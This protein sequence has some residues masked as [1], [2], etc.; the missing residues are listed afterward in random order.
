MEK[1]KSILTKASEKIYTFIKPHL[2][3]ETVRCNL[4]KVNVCSD[5]GLDA[6]CREYYT[7][8][9]RNVMLVLLVFLM[10]T[11]LLMTR[12]A[13]V[14]DRSMVLTRDSYGGDETTYELTAEKNGQSAEFE[15]ELQ[16]VVYGEDEIEAVFEQS[17]VYIE[18]NFLGEN[19]SCD[20]VSR[21][22]NLMDEIPDTGISVVWIS[23]D[24]GS[25]KSTGE[26]TDEII[27]DPR[28]ITL[29]ACLSYGDYQSE[30]EYTVRLVGKEYTSL[31]LDINAIKSYI[32]EKTAA[33]D[34]VQV[35]VPDTIYG[36]HISRSENENTYIIF[37]IMGI[38]MA[39]LV[40]FKSRADLKTAGDRRNAELML[41]Y[42]AFV[43]RLSLY[44]GAGLNIRGALTAVCGQ[45]D[46]D[47]LTSDIL[48][49]E[50][51]YSLNQ[52]NSGCLETDVYYDLGHRLGLTVYMKITSLLCQNLKKGTN[53][54][55]EQMATEELS[56]LTIR[57]ENARKRGEEAG[58]KLLFPMIMLLVT[59]MIIVMLPALMSF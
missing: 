27:N 16:P 14:T 5:A 26:I 54:L 52:L 9:I 18:E 39:A 8:L 50:I 56:A 41:R 4:R 59:V 43:E 7:G 1:K 13:F 49:E 46:E 36:Y 30:R 12:A 58:T 2:N 25:I 40:A 10:L 37:A 51:R 53:D 29:T 23:E 32:E 34:G 19:E 57:R 21:D 55:L 38:V 15:V 11:I 48:L 42:P 47:S 44:L 24:Y 3:M 31:E 35:T 6:M 28:L 17:F 33:E 45:T 22:L 20:Y